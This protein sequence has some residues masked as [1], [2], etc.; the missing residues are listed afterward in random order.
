MTTNIVIFGTGQVAREILLQIQDEGIHQII[1][2]CDQMKVWKDKEDFYGFKVNPLDFIK[3]VQSSFVIILASQYF[4]NMYAELN[5]KGVLANPNIKGIYVPDRY[6]SKPPYDVENVQIDIS[7]YQ[8]LKHNLQDRYSLQLLERIIKGRKSDHTIRL[9]KYEQMK[10]WSG[11]ED[12][13]NT[14]P[15]IEKE[16]DSIIID[17]GAYVGDS[18]KSL[19]KIVRNNIS[20]YY[21]LEP[22]ECNYKKLKLKLEECQKKTNCEFI[23][24]KAA[25]GNAVESGNIVL[26]SMEELQAASIVDSSKK[27]VESVDVITIDSLKLRFCADYYLKMDIEGSELKALQGGEEF[28]IEKHPNLAIC[29]YHKSEDI[30]EIPKY[31]KKIVPG[32]KI[33]LRGGNH[34][35]CIARYEA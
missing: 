34:T 7:E 12:Y 27:K 26:N 9:V 16:D 8:W 25:L 22:M 33:Y 31:I 11:G 13:W 18:I 10:G 2:V 5:D 28:I 30:I 23:A 4:D 19:C 14:V 6:R 24:M 35:I 21:A 20:K 17:A 1:G 32:Y 3:A 15:G 29:L